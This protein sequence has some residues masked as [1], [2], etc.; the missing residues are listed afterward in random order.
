MICGMKLVKVEVQAP[1]GA[2]KEAEK[3]VCQLCSGDLFYIL[4]INGHNHLNCAECGESYCQG[5][6]EEEQAPE[7][8]CPKCNQKMEVGPDTISGDVYAQCRNIVSCI[9]DGHHADNYAEL[10]QRVDSDRG[11]CACGED[12]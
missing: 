7:I 10:I 4:V 2:K 1:D 3:A 9:Y 12:H 5:N 11:R 6:C 8:L